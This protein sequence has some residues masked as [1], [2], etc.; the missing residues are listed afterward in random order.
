MT[1]RTQQEHVRRLSRNMALGSGGF[2]VK[3]TQQRRMPVACWVLVAACVCVGESGAV[4]AA[5]VWFTPFA[6]TG[7]STPGVSGAAFQTLDNPVINELGQVAFFGSME[8][9]PGGVTSSNDGGV[10]LGLPDALSLVVRDG[11]TAAS[12]APGATHVQAFSN[13][14]LSDGGHMYFDS[15]LTGAVDT[16]TSTG[17]NR[18]A[19]AG[20]PGSRQLVWRGN[21]AAPGAAGAVF[22]ASNTGSTPTVN[23][24]GMVAFNGVLRTGVS[25]V[26]TNTDRGLW[27]GMPNAT[28]LVAREGAAAVGTAGGT[29]AIINGGHA[30]NSSGEIVFTATLTTSIGDTTSVNNAAVYHRNSGGVL[31]MAARKGD[32]VVGTSGALQYNAFNNLTMNNAGRVLMRGAVSGTGVDSSNDSVVYVGL[33][34]ALQIL[35]REGDVAPGGSGA[36]FGQPGVSVRLFSGDNRAVVG[37]GLSD[38][39]FGLWHGEPGFLN[40][41]ALSGDTAPAAG[42]AVFSDT[43]SAV[44]ANSAGQVAFM[45]TLAGTGVDATNDGSLWVANAFGG[46]ELLVREGELFDVN[47]DPMVSDLRTISTISFTT[48]G[49]G[50]DDGQASAFNSLGQLAFKLSFTDGS[51]SLVV[52]SI[53]VPAPVA[54]VLMGA[55]GMG[56]L[57]S[58]RRR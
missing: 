54:G 49:S 36:S 22:A 57:V 16:G 26:N 47:I 3:T 31:A 23:A 50:N 41:L 4:G 43:F 27:A 51:T 24:S 5:T 48:N 52:A 38:G 55:C 10:W 46:L 30:L 11:V 29:Y 1:T 14:R 42:G 2:L 44:Q 56:M 7:Q 13:L 32:N 8:T 9:G 25:G 58:R 33:P 21:S 18:G 37:A 35:V 20:L 6:T 12:G 45:N 15:P 19:W 53:P 34:G 28:A 39:R 17:T 40:K